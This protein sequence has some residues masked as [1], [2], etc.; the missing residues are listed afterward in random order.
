MSIVTWP[1]CQSKRYSNSTPRVHSG[2]IWWWG[3]DDYR[4]LLPQR[5]GAFGLSCVGP[6]L[7]D[8]T[9]NAFCRIT[10][11]PPPKSQDS[12]IDLSTL[13]TSVWTFRAFFYR[14]TGMLTFDRH[15]H[16]QQWWK[17]GLLIE[18][19]CGKIDMSFFGSRLSYGD[20]LCR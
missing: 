10:T 11:G 3:C 1:I 16:R 8:T 19:W 15:Y 7:V 6:T 4:W 13:F 12:S 5:S 9:L 14:S 20:V 17:L 18:V 2:L